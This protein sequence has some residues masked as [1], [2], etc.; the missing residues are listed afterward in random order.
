MN[1]FLRGIA[2]AAFAVASMP[3]GAASQNPRPDYGVYCVQGRLVVEQKHIEE[4][5]RAFGEDVCRLDQDPTPT[6]AREK[7]VR[8]GG[9]G[10]ECSCSI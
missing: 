3:L 2:L 5:K 6:G 10:A 9:A 4:L 7:V 8:M 1:R